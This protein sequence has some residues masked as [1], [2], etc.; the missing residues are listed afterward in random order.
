MVPNLPASFNC[1]CFIM[2]K[3][4]QKATWQTCRWSEYLASSLCTFIP[5]VDLACIYVSSTKTG[6]HWRDWDSQSFELYPWETGLNSGPSW[7]MTVS[8]SLC[9]PCERRWEPFSSA[10]GT[11]F[12]CLWFRQM[13]RQR[14][15][16][17]FSHLFAQGHVPELFYWG[18]IDK[19]SK[20]PSIASKGPLLVERLIHPSPCHQ[21]NSWMP[22]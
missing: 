12:S 21:R 7:A 8:V 13:D 6:E 17:T 18:K 2:L 1:V 16:Q 9:F 14:V 4:K 19:P 11:E 22:T 3:A 15:R 5:S 10:L 20:K